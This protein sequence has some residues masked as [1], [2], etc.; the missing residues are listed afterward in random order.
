MSLLKELLASGYDCSVDTLYTDQFDPWLG[1]KV[2]RP[3]GFPL[4][5]ASYPL[6]DG[7]DK[8]DPFLLEFLRECSEHAYGELRHACYYRSAGTNLIFSRR[9]G[10]NCIDG[11]HSLWVLG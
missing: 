10:S 9:L 3:H 8:G 1:Q 7:N 2:P 6:P 5:P 4:F 11:S